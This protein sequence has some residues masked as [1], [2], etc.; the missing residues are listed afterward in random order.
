MFYIFLRFDTPDLNKVIKIHLKKT[1]KPSNL[2]DAD[3]RG[4]GFSTADLTQLCYLQKSTSRLHTHTMTR[5]HH[6][7]FRQFNTTYYKLRKCRSQ[8]K[9]LEMNTALF[10]FITQ[11]LNFTGS[12][13]SSSDVVKGTFAHSFF[14]KAVSQMK[15]NHTEILRK[16]RQNWLRRNENISQSL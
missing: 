5:S 10:R 15:Q 14:S 8:S 4:P 16:K 3:P 6:G 13:D 1:N 11:N 2:Q 7:R 12:E 9:N